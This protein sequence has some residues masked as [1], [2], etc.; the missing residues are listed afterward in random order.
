MNRA[1]D[2]GWVE[3]A[4]P[5]RGLDHLG[6]QAPC[7]ALYAQL[8]PGITN[9]TD[10][11]RYYSFYPWLIRSFEQRY[12]DHSINEFR[13]VL[14]R[15]ECLFALI[16][17]RHARVSADRDDGRHGAGMVGRLSLLRI[18]EDAH[19]INLDEHAA[20]EGANRYFLN[21]LGG[22]GQYYFGPLRD[23]RVLDYAS[24]GEDALPGYDKVRGGALAD[25]LA[26]VVPE[27]VFFRLLEKDK[28]RWTDLDGL[29]EFCP[30][31]L[32]ESAAERSLLLDLF[33]AKTDA[34]RFPEANNR[35]A[36]L[37][38]ILDLLS[39][40]SRLEG[41]SAESIYRAATYTKS[42][43]DGTNWDVA[44]L[45]AT[46]RKGW[47]TYQQNELFSLALQA[48]FAATLGA[49][50]CRHSGRLESA[51][52]AGEVCVGLLES[53][54]HLRARR[55]ADVVRELEIGLP[56]LRAWQDENHEMQRGWR[57]LDASSED[58]DLTR[59]ADEAL[60]L[61]LSLLARGIDENPYGEFDFDPDH[62]GDK[63]VHLLSFGRAWRSIWAD[64]TVEQLVRWLAVRWGVQRHLTVALR[65][66]RGERRDTFRIRP[67]DQELRV[68]EVPPPA[69]T[70]PRLGRAFQIL[71]DLDLTD[72]DD[73][74]PR[75]TVS[76]R[77]ELEACLAS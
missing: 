51:D 27:D 43:P 44:P 60:N 9:V 19:T 52:G 65:K 72:L 2:I 29:S 69:A 36:S 57:I 53:T 34:Y 42:L 10:R 6:V 39:R 63:E 26:A 47:G 45:L 11:A 14:R 15:A 3:P 38:L 24:Q 13:R 7:I 16:A 22:L 23:L 37:G 76:G 40:I 54:A 18:P 4:K 30:C 1:I 70:V 64:L 21:K 35:R 68:I 73:G 33:F 8:L 74:W 32:R 12:R 77:S 61:L 48:L 25:A 41:Y 56:P 58:S 49:I 50:N 67:L 55:V 46:A 62:F 71:R 28:M 20:L 75:L 31:A 5:I 59:L 17:I 66:L